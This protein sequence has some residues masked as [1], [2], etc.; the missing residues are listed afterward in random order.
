MLK[1]QK[2]EKG[3]EGEEKTKLENSAGVGSQSD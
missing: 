2:L 3:A 1:K